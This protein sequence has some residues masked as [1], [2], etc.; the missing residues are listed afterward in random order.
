M[1]RISELHYSNAYARTSNV[2]EFLEVALTPADDPSE[3]VVGFYHANGTL[4][5]EVT[6]DDPRVVRSIDPETG[7]VVFVLSADHLPILLTDP[8]G[9]GSTN[10]EAYALTN[11]SSGEVLDTPGGQH[12]I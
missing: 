8:D 12:A 11:T 6:L 10:Y 3:F 7:E 5:L 9:S 4:G 2:S 1:T